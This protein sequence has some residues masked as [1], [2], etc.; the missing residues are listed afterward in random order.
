[1][2]VFTGRAPRRIRRRV[3]RAERLSLWPRCGCSLVAATVAGDPTL[4]NSRV[5]V[6]VALVIACASAT[7]ALVSSRR[8]IRALRPVR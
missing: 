1:M 8:G 3:S 6:V 5:P 7:V 4:F 2:I